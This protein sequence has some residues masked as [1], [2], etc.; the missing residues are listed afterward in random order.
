MT[1][2]LLLFPGRVLNDPRSTDASIPTGT[3]F[4]QNIQP[5]AALLS[6]SLDRDP[7]LVRDRSPLLF[8]AI[9]LLTLYYRERT[10]VNLQLY[11]AVSTILDTIL[12]PQILCPQPDQ[13]SF[14]FVRAVQ[15]LILYKPVQYSALNARGVSDASQIESASKMNVRASWVLRLL[16]SRVSA[17]VGL[18]SI[19][20]GCVVLRVS[21][22]LRRR[23]DY[24]RN[25]QLCTGFRKSAHDAD[26]GG[27]HLAA[28]TLPR[29]RLSRVARRDPVREIRQLRAARGVQG[30]GRGSCLTTE[31]KLTEPVA[32]TTRLFA[33][34]KRQ[35]SDVRLAASVELV[36]LAA[37][38]LQSRTEAG[39][40]D[41]DGLRRFDDEFDS[42][43]EY[44]A[45]LVSV[46]SEESGGED[47]IAWSLFVPYAYFTRLTVRGFAFN[48]WR[49]ERKARLVAIR[50][51][52]IEG[53]KSEP[54]QLLQSNLEVEDRESIAKAVEVVE[55]M[56]LS[57]STQGRSLRSDF[58]RRSGEKLPWRSFG[59]AL[60]PDL[61]VVKT[62]K[63]S[64]DSLTCVVRPFS[65]TIATTN[66]PAS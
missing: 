52:E 24:M 3:S 20:N 54:A 16:V 36:A 39:V 55:E 30:A 4:F 65:H 37:N 17:F 49:A 29:L 56:M 38:A 58:G 31:R 1:C 48:K 13:L 34:L 47:P 10:P 12:A 25:S 66:D 26:T 33:T 19:A 62:L 63:W 40:L 11:R 42:W 51:G 60:T 44:W 57:V 28:T 18:P 35:P 21:P 2:E 9:L 27:H 50:R 7:R 46:S 45:P 6:T 64:T 8:H 15:L 22:A 41:A 53:V 61:D 5:W 32:Q 14:D 43:M 59:G 23:A